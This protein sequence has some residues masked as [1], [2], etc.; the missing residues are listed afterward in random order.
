MAICQAPLFKKPVFFHYH[1]AQK[2]YSGI[3]LFCAF[4]HDLFL[5][6]WIS[7]CYNISGSG[8]PATGNGQKKQGLAPLFFN[9]PAKHQQDD[10][11][12]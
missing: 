5:D 12:D 11:A 7:L 3:P 6:F 10:N 9:R 1:S 2:I 4:F 8:D